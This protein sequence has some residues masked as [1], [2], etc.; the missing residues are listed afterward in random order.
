MN[1][2]PL[3][4]THATLRQ[5]L[6][7]LAVNGLVFT[8]CY[9]WT[10]WLAGERGAQALAPGLFGRTVP[11]LPWMVV[12]YLSSGIAF[13]L[14]FLVTDDQRRLW[15]LSQRTLL[16]TAV[17]EVCFALMPLRFP[18]SRPLVDSAPLAVLF[19]MLGWMDQ[20]FNQLPSLHAAYA[21]VFW[22]SLHGACRGR[23]QQLLVAA[24]LALVVASTVFTWQHHVADLIAG[25][26]LGA[27]AVGLLRGPLLGRRAVCFYY[28]V[29]G[30]LS[31]VLLG[32]T[33]ASWPFAW[34]GASLLLVALAYAR[35][36]A[37]F[38][39]KRHGRHGL[40]TWICYAPYL[41]GYRLSWHWVRRADVPVTQCGPA[42][43]AGRR[44]S[45]AE[46]KSL[47]PACHVIDLSA[48]LSETPALRGN[49]Y[50]HIPMLDLH[51]PKLSVLRQ[52][53][54]TIDGLHQQGH[55]VYVHC[56]MGLSRSRLVARIATRG[57]RHES[58]DLPA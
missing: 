20:P 12:P 22:P 34:L 51:A 16:V 7:H 36:D 8:L 11:F 10:N 41:A 31:G 15:R 27:G 37:D 39:R 17:A 40:R 33:F 45:A 38:L 14:A 29:A 46:A 3:R 25:V 28:S 23:A 35:R 21:I 52:L 9:T 54:E 19:S 6:L 26:A 24:W 58:F 56:A 57:K 48:E 55:T 49:R 2:T 13:T 47:P 44:L 4:R 53:R 30:V 18:E 43:W 32:H 5:R 1:R 42:L 50:L